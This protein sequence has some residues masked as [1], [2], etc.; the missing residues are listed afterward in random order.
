MLNFIV[1]Q[2]YKYRVIVKQSYT[3]HETEMIGLLCIVVKKCFESTV[4]EKSKFNKK[5]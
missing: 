2:R 5:L 1:S 3:Q 4:R